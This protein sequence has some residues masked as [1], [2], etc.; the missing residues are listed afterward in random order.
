M[1]IC[2]DELSF[3]VCWGTQVCD[4]RMSG[5][6]GS[7]DCRLSEPRPHNT[8]ERQL[9][10]SKGWAYNPAFFSH[11]HTPVCFYITMWGHRYVRSVLCICNISVCKNT[12]HVSHSNCVFICYNNTVINLSI[13]TNESTTQRQKHFVNGVCPGRSSCLTPVFHQSQDIIVLKMYERQTNKHTATHQPSSLLFIIPLCS[14]AVFL[15][16][17]ILEVLQIFALNKHNPIIS[18]I[19]HKI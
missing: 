16:C 15:S 2:V 6:K 5:H 18:P 9:P 8:H 11:A 3:P 17:I 10:R 19:K 1:F 4:Q 12:L 7:H 13:I 14:F